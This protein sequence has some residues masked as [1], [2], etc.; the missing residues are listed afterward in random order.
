[1]RVVIFMLAWATVFK[2]KKDLKKVMITLKQN[3][4]CER[5][6]QGRRE[7]CVSFDCCVVC[8]LPKCVLCLRF[9][10]NCKIV[11]LQCLLELYIN[12]IIEQ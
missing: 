8:L 11:I 12:L 7:L 9:D 1:M 6:E 3:C 2:H 5:C 10:A 4:K